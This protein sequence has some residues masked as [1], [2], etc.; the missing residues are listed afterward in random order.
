MVGTSKILTVSYGTFSC[1]LEGFDDPF[2][3]MR[4][5]AEYFRDLAADDRYF[6]AEPPQPDAEMLHRIAEKEIQRKVEARV[7]DSG[8]HLRQMEDDVEAPALPTFDELDTGYEV[9]DAPEAADDATETESVAEKLS[10]IRAVVDKSRDAEEVHAE[11]AAMAENAPV[12]PS[13]TAD[14]QPSE[15]LKAEA[16]EIE[17]AVAEAEADA[18]VEDADDVAATIAAFAEQT[19]ASEEEV[20]ADES[21]EDSDDDVEAARIIKLARDDFDAFAANTEVAERLEETE[22]E[23]TEE[24]L[25]DETEVESDWSMANVSE[26]VAASQEAMS[27][28]DDDEDDLEPVAE[29][30]ADFAAFEQEEK[31]D[32]GADLIAAEFEASEDEDDSEPEAA[33]EDDLT[34]GIRAAMDDDVEDDDAEEMHDIAQE[35]AHVDAIVA[36]SQH[37]ELSEAEEDDVDGFEDDAEAEASPG[38]VAA[39]ARLGDLTDADEEATSDVARLMDET[40][41]KM[42]DSEG[43]RRRSAIAHLKAAVAAT[44]ADRLLKRVTKREANEAEEQEQYREDLSAVVRPKRPEVSAEHSERPVME[45]PAAPL[46]LVSELRVDG[47]EADEGT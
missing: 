20:M 8:V 41:S 44:K 12:D 2:S 38:M 34:A 26:L 19:E 11:D 1:T 16:D 14:W 33:Y 30:E 35:V 22:I 18:E 27:S 13:E 28:E 42:E 45:E 24:T 7:G 23:A 9:E 37:D 21:D 39:R 17:M 15:A 4:S 47:D 6:G 32:A 3:T 25:T 5:I 46:M 36:A 31:E 10:R 40:D 29:S 43:S